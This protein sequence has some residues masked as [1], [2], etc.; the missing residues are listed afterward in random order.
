MEVGRRFVFDESGRVYVCI[1]RDNENV[2][3]QEE[4]GIAFLLIV[5]ELNFLYVNFVPL[6]I[7]NSGFR[8]A[9]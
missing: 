5:L 2:Y 8:S 6:L 4:N 7:D 3:F 1:G 9:I